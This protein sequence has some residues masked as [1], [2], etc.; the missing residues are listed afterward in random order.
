MQTRPRL[1]TDRKANAGRRQCAALL[2]D[3]GPAVDA[4]DANG[5]TPLH[6]A[7]FHGHREI[8]ALLLQ[9]DADIKIGG[10][11][12]ITLFAWPGSTRIR[13]YRP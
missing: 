2:I 7:A 4:R 5:R 8:A 9:S 11:C 1:I 3:P 6:Q 12:G 13:R 10:L